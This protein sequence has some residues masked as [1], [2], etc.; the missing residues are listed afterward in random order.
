MTYGTIL[1]GW[2]SDIDRTRAMA[3][4]SEHES[5][6]LEAAEGLVEFTT[7]AE[8]WLP[9]S[10]GPRFQSRLVASG[11]SQPSISVEASDV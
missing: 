3:L 1:A 2:P 10:A 6:W 4:H 8:A 7:N 5:A 11:F 9:A